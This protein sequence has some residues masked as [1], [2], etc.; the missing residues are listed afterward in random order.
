MSGNFKA[1]FL[2][3]SI[4]T[5]VFSHSEA[6]RTRI[7][8]SRSLGQ[9]RK[10]THPALWFIHGKHIPSAL[11]IGKQVSEGANKKATS[12]LLWWLQRISYPKHIA[13]SCVIIG[14]LSNLFSPLKNRFAEGRV[15]RENRLSVCGW[16][17]DD[18]CGSC[19]VET[20]QLR[21]F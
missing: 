17:V 20:A 5:Q 1:F 7:Q 8:A 14:C 2:I 6:R 9:L 10:K 15:H 13:P 12:L 3:Y 18:V 4:L 16:G 19:S 21:V 11:G